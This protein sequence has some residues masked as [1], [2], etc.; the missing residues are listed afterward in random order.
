MLQLD[1]KSIIKLQR[2]DPRLVAL[3]EAVHQI[4]PCFV[5]DG[6]RDEH[7]QNM[8]VLKGT[9]NLK[10]PDSKHN[11][12]PSLAVDL[13]PLPYAPD[14]IKQLLYFAGYVMAVGSSHG[15]KLRWGGDWKM[16]QDPSR[17]A[18]QDLFHFELV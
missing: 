14:N 4:F 15:L 7:E 2:V 10:Y 16:R 18:P 8:E 3:V 6:Y 5:V 9:S 1:Q 12:D 13:A 11:S 17:N